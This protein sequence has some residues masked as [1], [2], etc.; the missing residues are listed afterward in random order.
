MKLLLES[1]RTYLLED[2][3]VLLEGTLE[4]LKTTYPSVSFDGFKPKFLNWLKDR[5]LEPK[6]IEEIHPI[7]DV[8]PTLKNFIS[9]EQAIAGKWVANADFKKAVLE[10]PITKDIKN[11]TDITNL[12]A[13]QLEA[14]VVYTER[15]KTRFELPQKKEVGSDELVGKFGEWSVYLPKTRESSCQIAGYDEKT[16]SPKT[17]WCTARTQGSNLFYNYVGRKDQNIFLF[18]VIK[19]NPESDNDWLSVG[20]VNGKSVFDGKSG[21][22]TVKRDNKGLQRADFDSIMGNQASAILAAMEAKIKE[23]GGVHPAKQM[24]VKAAK[25]PKVFASITSGLSEEERSDIII[26]IMGYDLSPEVLAILAKDKDK[27]VKRNVAGNTSTPPEMLATLAKDEDEYVRW[28]VAS[29]PSTPPEML[30][31]LAGDK[32]KHVRLYVALN[33]STPPE[34]RAKLKAEFRLDESK[35]RKIIIRIRNE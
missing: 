22:L 4:D 34:V 31:I 26:N 18:Y 21:G 6:R 23:Y 3:D 2:R 27:L 20:W 12:T 11:P 25:D 9:K 17:V 28:H 10:D 33:T 8:I 5:F 24:M 7:E 19:D 30:A 32:V 14:L 16:M 35:K 15:K 13:D 29:N 1:W